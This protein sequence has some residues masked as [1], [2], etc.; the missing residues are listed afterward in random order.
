MDHDAHSCTKLYPFAF[1]Y[2]LNTY[3]LALVVTNWE[4]Y[5]KPAVTLGINRS[6]VFFPSGAIQIFVV[7]DHPPVIAQVVEKSSDCRKRFVLAHS[8]RKPFKVLG[9]IGFPLISVLKHF[10]PSTFEP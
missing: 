9:D 7:I 5:C 6:I 10:T 3:T 4:M 8:H 2:T 1:T